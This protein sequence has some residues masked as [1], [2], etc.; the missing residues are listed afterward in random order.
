MC[1]D[2]GD[3]VVFCFTKAE[4]AQAFCRRF[5]GERFATRSRR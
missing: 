3:D 2:N 1:R 5:G 4:D